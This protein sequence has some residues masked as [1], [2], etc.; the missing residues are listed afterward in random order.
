MAP[1]YKRK[2]QHHCPRAAPKP[3]PTTGSSASDAY[4]FSFPIFGEGKK[5]YGEDILGSGK[6]Q[7]VETLQARE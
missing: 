3:V 7:G 4:F 2:F 6:A 5:K 1:E